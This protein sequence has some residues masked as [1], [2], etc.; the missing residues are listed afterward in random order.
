MKS[1]PVCFVLSLKQGDVGKSNL[2]ARQTTLTQITTN[3][4]VIIIWGI[5]FSVD[6]KHKLFLYSST[7]SEQRFVFSRAEIFED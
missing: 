1:T 3:L 4:V 5:I 6:G 7:P 2:E